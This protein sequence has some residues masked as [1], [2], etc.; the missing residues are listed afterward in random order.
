MLFS[1]TVTVGEDRDILLDQMQDYLDDW[2]VYRAGHVATRSDAAALAHDGAV[3]QTHRPL[4]IEVLTVEDDDGM[5]VRGFYTGGGTF[6]GLDAPQI[7]CSAHKDLV[8]WPCPDIQR[9]VSCAVAPPS[10]AAGA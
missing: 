1:N 3:V 2:L 4:I 9:L 6:I 8:V 10:A 5:H 7:A